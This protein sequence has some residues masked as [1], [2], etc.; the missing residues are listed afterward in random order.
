MMTGRKREPWLRSE[1]EISSSRVVL[2]IALAL[3]SA[4]LLYAV[5][6]TAPEASTML[7]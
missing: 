5:I 4:F 6:A 7:F 1:D 3:A 2:A